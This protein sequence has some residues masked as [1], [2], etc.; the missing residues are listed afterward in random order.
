[1]MTAIGI[2]CDPTQHYRPFVRAPDGGN[3]APGRRRT[4]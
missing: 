4:S 3:S 2:A 1:V